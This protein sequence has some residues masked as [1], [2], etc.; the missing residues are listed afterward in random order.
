MEFRDLRFFCPLRPV[1]A[2]HPKR[3]TRNWNEF[4]EVCCADAESMLPSA[5]FAFPHR[6]LHTRKAPPSRQRRPIDEEFGV[7]LALPA[8]EPLGLRNPALPE[9]A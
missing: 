7:E 9:L 4:S 3:Y 2:H 6:A 8:D 1:P 5:L